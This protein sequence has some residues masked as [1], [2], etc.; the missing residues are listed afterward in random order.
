MSTPAPVKV[1][2]KHLRL[3]LL[4][5]MGAV[6]GSLE[7][8][9]VGLNLQGDG[10]LALN[11]SQ[12]FVDDIAAD[13]RTFWADSR[14]G[15]GSRAKLD[16]IKVARIGTNGKYEADPF[17]SEF[18]PVSGAAIG[19]D[20]PFQVSCCVSL[21]TARRGPT[22]KGRIYL[23]LPILAVGGDG[24]VGQGTMDT[25]GLAVAAFVKNINNVPGIDRPGTQ[26]VVAS[27]K[28]YNSPVIGV[29]VGRVLDTIRSRRSQL[30]EVYGATAGVT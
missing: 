8:F 1:Y 19:T 22:G 28:G 14:N 16:A 13:A 2:A 30:D 15:I 11:L 26:V 29:R 20:H 18:A 7:R 3:T 5:S 12:V 9:S 21:V 27:S 4:G 25:V 23:P 6:A 17:I 24:T 10:S